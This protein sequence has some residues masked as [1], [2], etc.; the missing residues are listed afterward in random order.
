M[1]I[2]E[3]S[4]SQVFVS[5]IHKKSE[6]MTIFVS[7]LHTHIAE[8][9]QVKNIRFSIGYLQIDNQTE[10][11]PVYPV[12]LK[13]RD[14]HYNSTDE[15]IVLR[16]KEETEKERQER[17]AQGL[18]ALTSDDAK[19]F[20][21]NMVINNKS[22]TMTN[23]KD[24]LYIESVMFLLQTLVIKIQFTHFLKLTNFAE[25]IGKI[26]NRSVSEVHYIFGNSEPTAPEDR[27]DFSDQYSLSA[28]AEGRESLSGFSLKSRDVQ[29]QQTPGPFPREAVGQSSPVQPATRH[30]SIKKTRIIDQKTT[31]GPRPKE[32]DV[33]HLRHSRM[34]Q[35][36][37]GALKRQDRLKSFAR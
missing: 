22:S 19:M 15:S 35:N 10:S 14:L 34:I 1:K 16:L 2:V 4:I 31:S 6:L 37:E 23:T 7:K 20:Q 26:L 5:F 11:E 27:R 12:L 30:G 29:R 8:T 24:V 13:P 9:E 18:A 21:F 3:L 32:T 36:E 33:E 17:E 25:H 28:I